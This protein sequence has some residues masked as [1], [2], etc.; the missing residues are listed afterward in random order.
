EQIPDSAT[1]TIYDGN[2]SLQNNSETIAAL[3]MTDGGVATGTGTLTVNGNIT[4]NVSS[5]SALITGKLNLGGVTRTLDVVDGTAAIDLKIRGTISNGTGGITKTGSGPLS[6][7]GS[8]T[9]PGPVAINGG[10]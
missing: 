3:T 1:V 6:F 2:W 9:F 4:T 10:T 7:E 5:A 8:N